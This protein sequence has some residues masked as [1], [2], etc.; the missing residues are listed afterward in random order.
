M[1][2]V[3]ADQCSFCLEF[4]GVEAARAEGTRFCPLCGADWIAAEDVVPPRKPTGELPEL[5]A[6]IETAQR[7]PRP[8][9]GVAPMTIGLLLGLAGTLGVAL[10]LQLLADP[11]PP[12]TPAAVPVAPA[13]VHAPPSQPPVVVATQAPKPTLPSPPESPARR[14]EAVQQALSQLRATLPGAAIIEV[15]VRV[16]GGVA[17]LTGQVDGATTLAKVSTTAGEVFG[18]KAVDTRAVRLAFREHVVREGDS[19]VSLARHYYGR[20]DRWRTLWKANPHLKDDPAALELGSVVR[21]P[22]D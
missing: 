12:P 7:T 9:S 22:T 4:E 18:I 10:A 19:L 6:F 11:E 1:P 16:E 17:F 2:L 20:G 5:A 13:S 14:V 3:P 15:Q 8:S 21:I